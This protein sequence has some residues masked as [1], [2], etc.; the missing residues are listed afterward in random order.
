MGHTP[1]AYVELSSLIKK[2]SLQVLLYDPV[3]K[4]ERRPNE[5]GDVLCIV[6]DF[7]A[8]A[9]ILIRRLDQPDVVLAMLRGHYILGSLP[10]S[11][12]LS[13][14]NV[15]EM[16]QELFELVPILSHAVELRSNYIAERT[17]LEDLVVLLDKLHIAF[18][19]GLQ[20]PDQISLFGDFSVILK[21]VDD[22]FFGS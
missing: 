15:I 4:I 10:S 21:M 11:A 22:Q 6:E 19:I 17:C 8:L 9:L 16:L 20:T 7:D 2:R 18:V 3:G 1:D 5:P 14:L 12:L 13:T